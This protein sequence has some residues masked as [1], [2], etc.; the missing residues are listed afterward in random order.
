MANKKL[1]ALVFSST[2]NKNEIV[3]AIDTL[4]IDDLSNDQMIMI[5]KIR[6][7]DKMRI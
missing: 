3:Q 5:K 1:D 4:N 7:E 6:D 2:K